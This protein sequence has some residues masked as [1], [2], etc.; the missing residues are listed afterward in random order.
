MYLHEV[1]HAGAWDGRDGHGG[2]G[3]GVGVGVGGCKVAERAEVRL[4]EEVV[5]AKNFLWWVRRA[6]VQVD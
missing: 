2:V 6:G 4:M 1:E 3:V 5:C